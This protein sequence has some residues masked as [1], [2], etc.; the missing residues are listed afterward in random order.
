VAD[1]SDYHRLT[2]E[3]LSECNRAARDARYRTNVEFA[4]RQVRCLT[5]LILVVIA[6]A[7]GGPRVVV[8][9]VDALKLS[10]RPATI[11][12]TPVHRE[13]QHER[14]S[15]EANFATPSITPE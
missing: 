14:S 10:D 13:P 5:A 9:A 15:V 8:A 1:T 6:A 3:W 12:P 7:I 2:V 11:T 4:I